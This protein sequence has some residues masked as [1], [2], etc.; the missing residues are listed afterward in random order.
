MLALNL[1]GKR[2]KSKWNWHVH[3]FAT[4]KS[5]F[6]CNMTHVLYAMLLRKWIGFCLHFVFLLADVLLLFTRHFTTVDDTVR[7][8]SSVRHKLTLFV[9]L[10][11]FSSRFCPIK[12]LKMMFVFRFRT[13][14]LFCISFSHSFLFLK[15]KMERM[16]PMMLGD[17]F[18]FNWLK[19][20][21][22]I[23]QKSSQY[24]H[25]LAIMSA[26]KKIFK[27]KYFNIENIKFLI[28]Q[29]EKP[30]NS[31]WSFR[32]RL[33]LKFECISKRL[34]NTIALIKTV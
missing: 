28:M 6:L 20:S 15:K 2:F 9:D 14:M 22:D 13:Y 27:K 32:H 30:R 3:R 8:H 16:Y 18:S 25:Y 10:F 4:A 23:F 12:A 26:R 34:I 21:W 17:R 29:K 19:C 24:F 33:L 5:C 1:E 11:S 31:G 7:V